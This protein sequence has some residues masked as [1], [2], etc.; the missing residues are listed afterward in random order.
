MQIVAPSR[1]LDGQ[2]CTGNGLDGL[3]L[4]KLCNGI[5]FLVQ[6]Y[7]C[8]SINFT[9]L[10]LTTLPLYSVSWID[11]TIFFHYFVSLIEHFCEKIFDLHVSSGNRIAI[12]EV[13][14]LPCF[15]SLCLE[16]ASTCSASSIRHGGE[17][18]ESEVT[19]VTSEVTS[20]TFRERDAN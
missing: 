9:A 16:L 6:V 14:F 8:A 3:G 13:S 20:V 15:C 10:V 18:W 12:F 1:F 2:G 11:E 7:T 5:V 19:S 4:E 17:R